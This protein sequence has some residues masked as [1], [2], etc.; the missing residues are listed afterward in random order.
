MAFTSPYQAYPVADATVRTTEALLPIGSVAFDSEGNEFRYVKA[1]AAISARQAVRLNGSTLG[2]DDVRPTSAA[3]QGVLG[4]AT[5]AFASGDY[6]FVQ[7]RGRV[8]AAVVNSTAVGS[9]L[10]SG[11]T[12]GTLELAEATDLVTRGAVA[13]TTAADSATNG[14][15]IVLL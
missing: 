8:L 9:L 3:Q 4:V 15:Y 5:A 2:Y 14:A 11:T 1:G 7:T 13:I 6:G 12:A 10:A